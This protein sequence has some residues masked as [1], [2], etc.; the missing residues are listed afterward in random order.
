MKSSQ[1]SQFLKLPLQGEDL[2]IKTFSTLA[3]CTPNT[4]VFAKKYSEKNAIFLSENN[5]ILA[6]VALEYAGKLNCPH[7]LSENPR[8]DYLRILQEFFAPKQTQFGIHPT[9]VVE[10]GVQIGKEVYIG[11]NCYI[12]SQVIIGDR[13]YIHANVVIESET[14]IGHDCCIKSGA[15]IGQAGFGF[16]RDSNGVPQPFPQ[17][18]KIKIGNY[19]HI[20]A[21]TCVDRAALGTTIIDDNVKIDNLVHIA[22]ND[23]I[24]EN[25]LITA[26][27]VF[28]GGVIV[29]KNSWIAP[30]VCIKEK[31]QIGKNSFLGLGAVIIRD[32]AENT[33][34]VGNPAKELKI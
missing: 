33:V 19:V 4:V 8:M 14:Q 31:M 29:G 11:A 5:Q 12:G 9:A 17:L 24:K 3:E 28:S 20:G 13:T 15:I 6:I 18:G 22:H 32:V 26:G 34:V 7:I 21:N 23:E 27:V 30:N 1:I 16:E 10:I 25:T 2:E